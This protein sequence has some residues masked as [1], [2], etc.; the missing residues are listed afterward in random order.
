MPL[1]NKEYTPNGNIIIL[2]NYDYFLASDFILCQNVTAK[3]KIK[4]GTV[5]VTRSEKHE[6][7]HSL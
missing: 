3:F 6:H 5:I 2:K 7:Q 1:Q 4:D